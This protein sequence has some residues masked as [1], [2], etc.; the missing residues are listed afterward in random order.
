MSV[1]LGGR[2]AERACGDE[3]DDACASGVGQGA[4]VP[5]GVGVGGVVGLVLPG[6]CPPDLRGHG[7]RVVDGGCGL[8]GN[9]GLAVGDGLAGRHAL[10]VGL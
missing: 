5:V 1:G 4:G 3:E 8:W 7:A 10:G 6:Q 9:G 2:D